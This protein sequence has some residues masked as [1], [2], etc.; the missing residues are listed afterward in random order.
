MHVNLKVAEGFQLGRPSGYLPPRR[1]YTDV[2][3]SRACLRPLPL[4]PYTCTFADLESKL[5]SSHMLYN[6]DQ[7]KLLSRSA[8]QCCWHLH[9]DGNCLWRSLGRS[10][11]S[12]AE[13]RYIRGWERSEFFGGGG[14]RGGCCKW[15]LP[16]MRGTL[17]TRLYSKHSPYGS[18][19]Q[20]CSFVLCLT[21][22]VSETLHDSLLAANLV[23]GSEIASSSQHICRLLESVPW[24]PT[25]NQHNNDP[26]H[27]SCVCGNRYCE[28]A[29]HTH[30]QNC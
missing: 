5:R 4:P 26:R 21:L 11:R 7:V 16:P 20:L 8:Q 27:C 23:P 12:H 9:D 2:P 19:L 25:P 17:H 1:W 3:S 13:L 29:V 6:I 24:C 15:I 14:G 28:I 18:Q 30:P 10:A 22:G